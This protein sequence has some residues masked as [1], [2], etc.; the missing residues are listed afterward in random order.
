MTARA[1]ASIVW[2]AVTSGTKLVFK[3]L[4]TMNRGKSQVKKGARVFNQVLR[5]S[6]IPE[7]VAFNITSSFA[8]PG[9]EILK[10]RN[11]FKLARNLSNDQVPLL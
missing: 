10:I 1:I 2:T 6:G 8:D 3:F 5:E 4:W 11:L 9:I 7:E